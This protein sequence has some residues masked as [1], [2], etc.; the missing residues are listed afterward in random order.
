[1]R[2]DEDQTSP[3]PCKEPTEKSNSSKNLSYPQQKVFCMGKAPKRTACHLLLAPG[4]SRTSLFYIDLI[5]RTVGKGG[6]ETWK[7]TLQYH[8]PICLRKRSPKSLKKTPSLK[9]NSAALRVASQK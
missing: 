5:D 6:T 9:E 2:A 3:T 1:L 4:I 7:R 8:N